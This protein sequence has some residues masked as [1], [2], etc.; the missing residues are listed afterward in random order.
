MPEV[1]FSKKGVYNMAG[2]SPNTPLKDLALTPQD[3]AALTPAAAKLTLADL[4]SMEIAFK[5]QDQRLQGMNPQPDIG[6]CCCCCSAV[7]NVANFANVG[8]RPHI[9]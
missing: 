1:N 6:C 9:L 8:Q 4:Q 2:P 7:A 3:A 5:N